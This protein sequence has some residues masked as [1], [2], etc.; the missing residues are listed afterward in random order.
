MR[1]AFWLL[2]ASVVMLVLPN[3]AGA[4]ASGW[5]AELPGIADSA[6]LAGG[7]IV[8][9]TGDTV[10]MLKDGAVLW[11][12]KAGE[13]VRKLA[14]GADGSVLAAYGNTLA[15]L[16]ADGS[17]VWKSATYD[18]VYML[19][20]LD[21]GTILAGYEYGLLAFGPDDGKHLWEHYAHEECDT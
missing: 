21:D 5:R 8:V 19:G 11:S 12:W 18:L 3:A 13:D 1:R 7:G 4:S 2:M 9:A 17:P 20:I 16:T 15:K 6:V 10:S 14:A